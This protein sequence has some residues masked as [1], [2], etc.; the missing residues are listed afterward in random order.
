MH[1]QI[2]MNTEGNRDQDGVGEGAVNYGE[3]GFALFLL[4][5]LLNSLIIPS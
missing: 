5:I 2:F 3:M 4:V 1:V